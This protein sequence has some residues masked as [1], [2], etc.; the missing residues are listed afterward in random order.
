VV[1]LDTKLP[2]YIKTLD[3]LK[4]ITEM[5]STSGMKKVG[6]GYATH[7]TYLAFLYPEDGGNTISTTDG[8]HPQTTWCQ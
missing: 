8:I 7:P 1:A 6:V 3:Y 5:A 2:V 4:D